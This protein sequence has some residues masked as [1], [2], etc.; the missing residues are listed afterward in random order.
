[1]GTDQKY[2]D[3]ITNLVERSI[4]TVVGEKNPIVE[5]IISNVAVG[6]GDPSQMDYE[7]AAAEG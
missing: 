3:S 5:S 6:A 7:C 4:T 1:M 2:T